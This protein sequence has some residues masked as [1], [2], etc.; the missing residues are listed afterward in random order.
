[1]GLRKVK[2]SSNLFLATLILLGILAVINFLSIHHFNRIDLTEE[3]MYSISHST[4]NALAKLKDVV[5]IKV[6]FSKELPPQLATLDSQVKDM[7][8]E[9][10]AY[11]GHNLQIEFID[12]ASDPSL[13]QR[14]R[15]IGIPKVQLNVFQK[16]QAQLTNVYLG[17]MVLYQDRKE[18][19]PIIQ[20]TRNLEYDLTS[21]I[22]RVTQKEPKTVAFL[23]EE[24]ESEF[25]QSTTK[26]RED[27]SKQYTLTTLDLKKGEKIPASVNTLIVAGPEE[28][29]ERAQY[30]IDQF[31]MRGG[32]TIFLVDTIK[33]DKKNML[34][35]QQIKHNLDD[36][37]GGYGVKVNND[38]A[39]DRYSAT[40][41]F[42]RGF[43]S[44]RIPYPF[45]PKA[46]EQNMDQKNPIVNKLS[47]ITFPWTSSLD[48]LPGRLKTLG[49][50]GTVLAKTSPHGWVAKGSYDLDPG[51]KF[52]MPS[53]MKS[54]PL[55]VL[56]SGK[57]K[58]FFENKQVPPEVNP[59]A[60][61][62]PPG[63]PQ[64]TPEPGPTI[65]ESPMTQI[66]V[67]GNSRMITDG[68]YQPGE[69]ASFILNCVD[70]LTMGE[71]LIGIRSRENTQHPL[72]PTEPNQRDLIRY[73]NIFGVSVIL[74]LFGLTRAYIIKKRKTAWLD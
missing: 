35:T 21:A 27:L 5:N 54:Y 6:Y 1:M 37:L 55:A 60:T 7:L 9:Y 69:N 28:T 68:F 63:Q 71:D 41:G 43:F 51:Q 10:K 31:I 52:G 25:S 17:M 40:V 56:L 32:K 15:F 11:S 72:K 46:T 29:S 20:D 18:T 42:N 44:F 26:I 62:S 53:E 30:E 64:A 58:S 74:I 13:E 34:Q 39:L 3:K 67:V 45:W 47:S 48:L 8:D 38:L 24:P 65:K 61:Q 50:E 66:L 22:I 23:T 49:A 2:Y 59:P 16:D 19:I 73:L 36:M 57:F 4:K 14:M 33:L 12:P 70:W